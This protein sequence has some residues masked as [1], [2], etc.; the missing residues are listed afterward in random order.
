MSYFISQG[1][2]RKLNQTTCSICNV[3]IVIGIARHKSPFKSMCPLHLVEQYHVQVRT[4]SI[5]NAGL[6]VFVDDGTSQSFPL[7]IISSKTP[8]RRRKIIFKKGDQICDYGGEI[9]ST[10]QLDEMYGHQGITAPYAVS[11]SPRRNL[12]AATHRGVGAFINHDKTRENCFLESNAQRG[13]CTIVASKTLYNGDELFLDYGDE[14]WSNA[15][16]KYRTQWS[17]RHDPFKTINS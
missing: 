13:I 16:P 6:G 15:T 3:P 17:K 11:I 9:L 7:S 2:R 8:S 4:S 14:Y 1:K 10:N 12:D 5:P